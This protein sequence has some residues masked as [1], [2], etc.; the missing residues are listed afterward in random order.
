MK[1]ILL[2]AALSFAP[3]AFAT[4]SDGS[5]LLECGG[6]LTSGV[7]TSLR[8]DATA[9]PT[10][11]S[12]VLVH[13]GDAVSLKCQPDGSDIAGTPTAGQN[14]WDCAEARG[15]DGKILVHIERGGFSGIV[16]AQVSQEQIFPLKPQVIGTLICPNH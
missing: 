8:I 6:Q 14:L 2:L 11:F 10:Y 7:E 13:G 15:G 9:I 3:N 1:A 12:G 4:V 5:A 16:T